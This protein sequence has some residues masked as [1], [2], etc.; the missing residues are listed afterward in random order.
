MEPRKFI[1]LLLPTLVAFLVGGYGAEIFGATEFFWPGA[2]AWGTII[3]IIDYN[4]TM[5]EKM[6]WGGTIGRILLVISSALITATVGDHILFKDTIRNQIEKERTTEVGSISQ[7]P[8]FLKLQDVINR[9]KSEA[10]KLA[11]K[12]QDLNTELIRE[13]NDGGCKSECENVKNVIKRETKNLDRLNTRIDNNEHKYNDKLTKA[14]TKADEVAERHDIIKEI[15]YLYKY[16][17]SEIAST[18]IFILLS[19]MVICIETLPLLLKSGKTR[20]AILRKRQQTMWRT[21]H[22]N[23]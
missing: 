19:A 13:Q 22:R 23:L 17:F 6:S 16:I 12:I 11:S 8:E 15:K 9:D 14:E 4:F 3:F 2:I 10:S 20:K 18:V 5:I 21:L 7:R 1:L